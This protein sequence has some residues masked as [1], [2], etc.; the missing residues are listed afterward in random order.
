MANFSFHFISHFEKSKYKAIPELLAEKEFTLLFS[1]LSRLSR[2]A[3][4]K[5]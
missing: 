5:Y 1:L 4:K 2:D 3:E